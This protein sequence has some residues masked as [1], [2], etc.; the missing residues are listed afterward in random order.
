MPLSVVFYSSFEKSLGN[1]ELEQK[2]VVQRIL[3][4]ITAYYASNCDLSEAKKLEP[5]FFY[6]QLRRPYYEAGVEK[7][8]RI[9]IYR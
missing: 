6:K 4:A 3:K 5:G 7:K 1:L 2:Q 8:I 9:I